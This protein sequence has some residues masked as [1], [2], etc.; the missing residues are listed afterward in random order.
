MRLSKIKIAG[1]KSFVDPTTIPLPSNLVG[2]VGP[3]GCGKSNTID[4]VRWVMGESNA[5]HLRGENITDVIFNGST[6]RKP[7]GQAAIELVFDNSDGTMGGQYAHYN[8]VSVKRV[9]TREGV[10]SYFLNSTRCRRRDITDLFLGTGL[11]P[12]SYAIIEQ[13]TISRLI[14]AKPEEMRVFLEEAAGISKYKERRRETENRIRHTRENLDRLSDLREE[15]GK[16]LAHLQRQSKTAERYKVLKAD[17]RLHKA[18]LQALRWKNL[19]SQ[20]GIRE[21]E[22]RELE[23]GFEAQIARQRAI[24]AELEQHRELHV[25]ATETFNDVQGRFY[26]I[27]A[28][29]ARLEQTIHH[30]KERRRN[31]EE[32][33]QKLEQSWNEIQQHLE[34]DQRR[35][36]ELQLALEE[37]EPKLLEQQDT[38]A[39]SA[40][41]LS[42]AES[43][44]HVLQGEW[45]DFNQRAAEPAQQAQVDRNQLQNLDNQQQQLQLRIN[46]LEEEAGQISPGTLE[47]DIAGQELLLEEQ[48]H[49]SEEMLVSL[50]SQKEQI[51]RQREE[52]HT[53]SGQQDEIR[54]QLQSQRGRQASLEAL[55]QAALGKQEGSVHQ[56]LESCGLADS[57]RLAEDLEVESGWEHAVETVLGPHLEAVCVDGLDPLADAIA[58]LDKGDLSLFETSAAEIEFSEDSLAARIKS[59][60][61]VSMLN[62]IYTADDLTHALSI[63]KKLQPHESVVTRDG[64][65][66]GPS[67]LRVS[68]E[69][70]E[71]AGVLA[72]EQ[73]LKV[74]IGNIEILQEQ[75]EGIEEQLANGQTHLQALEEGRENLQR[76]FNQLN[77]KVGEIKAGLSGK[78][79]RLEQF[80]QRS[81]KVESELEE[82]REQLLKNETE[83]ET[84]RSRLNQ[85]LALMEELAITREALTGRRE[86]VQ[87][88]LQA[89]R[90]SAKSGREQ[91]QSLNIQVQ[92]MKTQ[93]GS[94]MDG[95]ER[96]H[97]QIEQ[98]ASRREELKEA[99]SEK[100][101][102]LEDQTHELEHQLTRRG[103]VE[104]EMGDARAKLEGIDHT[105]RELDK[106]RHQVEQTG[107]E[108][109]SNLEQHRMGA[110]ELKVRRQTLIEALDESGHTL[111]ELMDEMPDEADEESW[112]QQVNDIG[113]KILRLGA[114]NL[115][116]IEEYQQQSERKNYLDAQN[117]DLNKALETLE[118]AIRKIDKETR[119]RFKETF[120]KVNS[121]VKEM[122]PK[123]FG[124][125]HAYLE[126]TGDDLLD[127]G[128]TIMARPPGKRNSSIQLLSGG[129]K[130]LT[131]VALVFSIFQ[132]NP[133][134]F[135]MLDEVDAPLDDA[136]VGRFC[137]I[138]KEMSDKTQFIFITHNKITMELA[139]QLNG[140]TMKEPGVSR[141]VAVDVQ[142]AA[143]LAVANG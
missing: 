132:L 83:Q 37:A 86:E 109:R 90:D 124:G 13:G 131:A 100:D 50:E 20:C 93:L 69:V 40:A 106:E 81:Q 99:L 136:N 27:G 42:E 108:I 72:R 87:N 101:D 14:E 104:K 51:G 82:L 130:A 122:F 59:P 71:H 58:N 115:A 102:P 9:V 75:A 103:L 74:L 60:F 34:N 118:G 119:T 68:K 76:E 28:E 44:M 116:A 52:N 113:Q 67:W 7:V 38:E 16:Q 36:E 70:D 143:E 11:G 65:W 24:E 63:R 139:Q 23:T 39:L 66:M 94:T 6:S 47:Q 10:S 21:G 121:G 77:Q 43:T 26:S 137:K 55:Q 78:Q 61:S 8:E 133:A 112:Q 33:L 135:C 62:G 114:I 73:E 29:I 84:V 25:E 53:L 142:E 105:M 22:I 49:Q 96:M 129:E 2:I 5:K 125:G 111:L 126:L 92:T 79:S 80:R 127:T 98:M 32:D 88:Q 123:L 138:V 95:L 30:T 89:L 57:R 4:A 41:A 128:V 19:D 46:K 97:N 12:R 15:L 141:L 120:D 110:Q 85:N 107:Q 54:S 45:D 134:P 91:L 31:Q 3:N 64:L 48:Q 117:E 18:Q 35:I 1:F 17:E 56:W 140:V